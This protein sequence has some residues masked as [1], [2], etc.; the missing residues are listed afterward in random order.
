MGYRRTYYKKRYQKARRKFKRYRRY[1]RT[2]AR[3]KR[4]LKRYV[5][6]ARSTT[7]YL[8]NYEP[9]T[10]Q[11]YTAGLEF[12]LASVLNYT[13]F[14]S[15]FQEY[16]INCVVVKFTP[17]WD[18][19]DIGNQTIATPVRMPV[20][21]W[22][23]DYN[24]AA[25]PS[26]I[27]TISEFANYKETMFNK[28]IKIKIWPAVAPTLYA[29][30]LLVGYGVKRRQWIRSANSD[31]KHYGLKFMVYNITP[32]LKYAWNYKIKYYLSFRQMY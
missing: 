29:N 1:G 7:I 18:T 28:P 13:E 21:G 11:P 25:T 31:V 30:N 19:N 22:A 9:A 23:I 5:H 4:S 16:R 15:L 24:D 32:N 20:I 6:V 3:I 26:S 27:D 17:T 12:Q 8:T 10:T 2:T 14:T